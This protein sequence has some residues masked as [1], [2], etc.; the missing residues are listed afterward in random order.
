MPEVLQ[1]LGLMQALKDLCS[2]INAKNS[3]QV[4]LLDYGMEERLSLQTEI[5]IYRI[6]QE[7]LSNVIKHSNATEAILQFNRSGNNI[8]IT[9]E[10]NGSGFVVQSPKD[11]LHTGI[12]IIKERVNFLNGDI[13]IDSQPG[14]GTTV[15]IS[16]C[17]ENK[18]EI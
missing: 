3:L 15:M 13:S 8:N 4:S 1:K 14:I 12:D 17:T 16:F 18:N 9:V 11:K 2:T 6:V 7:L 5:I 10:D